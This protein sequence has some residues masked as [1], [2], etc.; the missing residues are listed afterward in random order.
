M[1]ILVKIHVGKEN[2]LIGSVYLSPSLNDT[3]CLEEIEELFN[4]Y[5]NDFSGPCIIGGDFNSRIGLLNQHENANE[6]FEYCNL[7]G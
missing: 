3:Q 5:V 7:W 6:M 1:C 4:I 2:I